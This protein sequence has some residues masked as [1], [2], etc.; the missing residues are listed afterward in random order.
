MKYS[1]YLLLALIFLSGIP[2]VHATPS[3]AQG[4]FAQYRRITSSP[5]SG[6]LNGTF[7]WTVTDV[8]GQPSVAK[9]RVLNNQSSTILNFTMSIDLSTRTEIP[10]YLI[11]SQNPGA[12]EPLAGA[13]HATKTF[14]W[15][16]SNPTIGTVVETVL[17]TAMVNGTATVT[18]RSGVVMNCWTLVS[19]S[20]GASGFSSRSN[21]TLF[22][23]YDQKTGLLVKLQSVASSGNFSTSSD[24]YLLENTN[25]NSLLSVPLSLTAVEWASL[26]MSIIALI[27]GGIAVAVAI[28][29]RQ[30]RRK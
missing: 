28:D 13:D 11:A 29:L 7:K 23:M 4:S 20:L 3:V 26:T 1:V 8:F 9:I 16:D 25:I 15:I 21:A 19:Q 18:L 12:S 6:V 14:F 27:L 22:F 10:S 17:G 5:F 30:F 2:A 24:S